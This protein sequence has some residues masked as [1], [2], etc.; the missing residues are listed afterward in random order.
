MHSCNSPFSSALLPPANATQEDGGR[1]LFFL[2]LGEGREGGIVSAAV[3]NVFPSCLLG[4][5]H[6]E[7]VGPSSVRPLPPTP[8]RRMRTSNQHEFLVS[9]FPSPSFLL[10]SQQEVFFISLRFRHSSFAEME[11]SIKGED[12]SFFFRCI[13]FFF[14]QSAE[15]MSFSSSSDFSFPFPSC[16]VLIFPPL[17]FIFVSFG[18]TMS[19]GEIR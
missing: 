6:T 14:P 18:K 11:A 17:H 16:F 15:P 9:F 7:V 1:R 4:T 8:A 3:T 2:F 19:G 13:G 10:L 5:Y 12:C